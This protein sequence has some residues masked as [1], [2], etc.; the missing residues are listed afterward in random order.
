MNFSI[1]CDCSIRNDEVDSNNFHWQDSW[2]GCMYAYGSYS[3]GVLCIPTHGVGT[4]D[5][6]LQTCTMLP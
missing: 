5:T 4:Q 3:Q 1:R 6:C 2:Q